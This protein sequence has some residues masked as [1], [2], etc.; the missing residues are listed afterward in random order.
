MKRWNYKFIGIAVAVTLLGLSCTAIGTEIISNEEKIKIIEEIVETKIREA[1]GGDAQSGILDAVAEKFTLDAEETPEFKNF[2]RQLEEQTGKK[3]PASYKELENRYAA[4]AEHSYPIYKIGDDVSVIFVLH[5]KPFNVRGRYYRQDSKFV[6]VG[7]KK[8]LKTNLA[9]DIAPRFDAVQTKQLRARFVQQNINRYQH[10]KELYLARLKARNS[11]LIHRL[12]GN[13]LYNKKWL[14]VRQMVQQKYAEVRARQDKLINDSI[15]QAK[16]HPDYNEKIKILESIIQNYPNHKSLS[17]VEVLLRRFKEEHINKLIADAIKKAHGTPDYNAKF[18]ILE[19]IIQQYPDHKSLSAV[20][21]ILAKYKMEYFRKAE[22]IQKIIE[23]CSQPKMNFRK[24][25][26]EYKIDLWDSNLQSQIKAQFHGIPKADK[27][28]VILRDLQQKEYRE[29]EEAIKQLSINDTKQKV[30]LVIRKTIN[31]GSPC[32]LWIFPVKFEKKIGNLHEIIEEIG[33][34]WRSYREHQKKC[35]SLK[36][37]LK[38]QQE[39]YR[40][41]QECVRNGLTEYWSQFEKANSAVMNIRSELSGHL[42]EA[43]K[44]A[45]LMKKYHDEAD[46]MLRQLSIHHMKTAIDRKQLL[47]E[48]KSELCSLSNVKGPIILLAVETIYFGDGFE[49]FQSWYKEYIPSNNE[50]EWILGK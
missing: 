45:R 12:Q 29:S 24:L 20:K 13:V 40:Q 32:N 30:Q 16:T 37:N 18:R 10:E 49:S 47:V 50:R 25:S 43:E 46:S 4:T 1:K 23:C 34:N 19:S 28:L 38:H 7:S 31:Q 8:I 9:K 35:T 39:R 6:W 21:K 33:R 11:N 26:K 48:L 44:S 41:Y 5:G 3:Y 2:I 15:Q 36:Q 27:L 17:N 22:E 14:S 42:E